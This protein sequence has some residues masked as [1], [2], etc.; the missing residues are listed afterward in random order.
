MNERQTMKPFRFAPVFGINFKCRVTKPVPSE[1]DDDSEV[2]RIAEGLKGVIREW[3]VTHGPFLIHTLDGLAEVQVI[4]NDTREPRAIG[5]SLDAV[6]ELIA[7]IDWPMF[8]K[9][10]LTLIRV[11]EGDIPLVVDPC[12]PAAIT[13]Q[14]NAQAM[15]DLRGLLNLLDAFQYMAIDDLG[16]EEAENSQPDEEEKEEKEEWGMYRYAVTDCQGEEV[17]HGY[18]D[19]ATSGEAHSIV[20]K[21]IAGELD[22]VEWDGDYTAKASLCYCMN[23]T[24]PEGNTDDYYVTFSRTP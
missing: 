17:L 3:L 22:S 24:D 1:I 19:Q 6:K 20:L 2:E 4:V 14:E 13:P 18:C 15:I 5:R 7:G 8:H 10:K 21:S 23:V 16:V 9:Q 12:D 11:A